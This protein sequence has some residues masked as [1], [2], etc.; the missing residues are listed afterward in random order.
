MMNVFGIIFA[1]ER[2]HHTT[3]M[4]STSY[5]QIREQVLNLPPESLK[6]VKSALSLSSE[7][8]RKLLAEMKERPPLRVRRVEARDFSVEQQWLR[9]NRHLYRGQYLAV[10]GNQLIAH[11]TDPKEVMGNAR[12]SGKDF[13]LSRS[14]LEG[15]IY[16]GGLW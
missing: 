11:G 9:E 10:S 12:A 3:P 8:Q 15:E 6:T 5:E 7:E 13:L 1:V 14:P 4:V 16:G 2:K